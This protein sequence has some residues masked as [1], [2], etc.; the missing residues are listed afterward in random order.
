M[1]NLWP[2]QTNF[3]IKDPDTSDTFNKIWLWEHE[4]NKHG[5]DYANILQV[6]FP[7][8]YKDATS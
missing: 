7:L 8:R 6:L 1:T 5:K 2:P 3:P 4:W